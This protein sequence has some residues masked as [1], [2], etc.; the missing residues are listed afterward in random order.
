MV[1]YGHIRKWFMRRSVFI[2]PLLYLLGSAATIAAHGQASESAT[3]RQFNITAGGMGS[4]FSRGGGSHP[5]YGPSANFLSGPG[6][7]VDFHFT[8]W[9]QLEGEA[10]WLRFHAAA[11]E[12]QDNYL[13]GPKVPVVRFGRA[14][15]YGKAMIGLGRMTFPNKYGYGTFTA[16]AFG[17]G[18]EYVLSRKITAR[19]DFEFQDWPNFLPGETMRPYGVSVGMAYRLF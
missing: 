8:H 9:I 18:M 3:A 11:G 15:V 10:R 19:G 6:V 5:V 17:G 1:F 13:I 16:L 7:Y 2:L 4:A 14:Q 12:L